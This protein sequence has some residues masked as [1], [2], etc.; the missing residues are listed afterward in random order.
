MLPRDA[1]T[2]DEIFSA[3]ILPDRRSPWPVDYTVGTPI[4]QDADEHVRLEALLALS[5]ISVGDR[6]R[7]QTA[8]ADVITHPGNARDPWIP[9]AAAIAGIP[10]GPAFLKDLASRRA[11]TDSVAVAG[12]RRTI[13]KIARHHALEKDIPRVVDLVAAVPRSTP[14]FAEAMLNG[15]AEGWPQD[16]T[17]APPAF[18]P[19]QKSALVTAAS[20][21]SPELAA[22]F[23]RLATRWNHPDAFKP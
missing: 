19:E 15:L 4:L 20:G 9:D 2:L 23:T 21:A 13:H 14:V 6:Q 5:E 10:F 22:A 17:S 18:T 16:T 3:G 1:G 11:P 8:V 12:M 7:A